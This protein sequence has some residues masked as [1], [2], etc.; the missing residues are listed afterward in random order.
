MNVCLVQRCVK[1]YEYYAASSLL[2]KGNNHLRHP[3]KV[4]S[5]RVAETGWMVDHR[6]GV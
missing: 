6:H 5:P 4:F 3:G 1:S 2:D